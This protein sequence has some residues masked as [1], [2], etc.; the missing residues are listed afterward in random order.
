MYLGLAV[1]SRAVIQDDINISF[2]RKVFGNLEISLPL[3]Q[4]N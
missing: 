2:N 3:R 1:K 4:R